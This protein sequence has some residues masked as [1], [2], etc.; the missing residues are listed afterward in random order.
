MERVIVIGCPGSGKSTFSKALHT[1]TGL[2]LFHLDMIY[3]R[4]DRTTC[5][6]VEFDQALGR[7]LKT[8]QWI[9]DGNYARTLPVRLARC[10]TVFWL[11]YPLEVCLQGIEARRGKPRS[12]MP[13]IETEEDPEFLEF[14]RGF[15]QSVRPEIRRMLGNCAP[16]QVEIFQSR[17]MAE[18]F[19]DFLR[20]D[21]PERTSDIHA[22]QN[23]Q[24]NPRC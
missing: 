12:D 22:F 5:S 6:Q 24:Q 21:L 23:N 18:A 20:A 14:V 15:H 10:D 13:W 2:P 4:A 3:H 19:L 11:D 16:K 9:L 17:E 7:I 1:L 8:D